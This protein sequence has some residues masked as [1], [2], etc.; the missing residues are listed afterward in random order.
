MT[1]HVLD[2][3]AG[4]RLFFKCENLQKTGAFKARGATNAVFSLSEK[5]AERGVVTSSSGNHGAAV[6]WAAGLRG[7]PAYIVMP[8][9][10]ARTKQ[11]SVARYGG[12]ITFCDPAVPARE[13]AARQVADRTRAV[14]IHPYDDL[15]VMAGQGTTALELLEQLPELDL[16]LC[17]VGGGGQLSGVAVAAKGMKPGIRI[18]GVE[19]SGADDAYRSFKAGYVIHRTDPNTIADGLRTSLGEKTFIEI[20]RHVDEIVTV[21]E[22]SIV[23]A[24]RLLWAI[25]KIIVEPSGAVPL[26]A[27]LERKLRFEGKHVALI[28]SGGNLDL[29]HLPW[30]VATPH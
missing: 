22:R 20:R 30:Q 17:P 21:S 29:D 10:A 15:R 4:A 24:M 12:E 19:P 8:K 3:Q 25:L 14:F 23:D 11:A 1:S 28:L 9:N 16:I 13:A 27:I 7:I 6:A 26:A 18:V 2:A 5:E